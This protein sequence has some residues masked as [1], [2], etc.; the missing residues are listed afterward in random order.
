[1]KTFNIKVEGR[2]ASFLRREGAIICDN[3]DYQIKFTFDDEWIAHETKTA[4]FVWGGLYKDVEFTGDTCQ[5]PTISGA[6]Q[7]QVGVYVE[8]TELKTTTPA[9][10]PCRG[11]I[12]GQSN[13][14][15]P[16]EAKHYRDQASASADRAEEAAERSEAAAT[17]AG[18]EAARAAEAEIDKIIESSAKDMA[19]CG[20][21]TK[22]ITTDPEGNLLNKSTVLDGYLCVGGAVSV[23]SGYSLTDYIRVE[24]GAAYTFANTVANYAQIGY[25]AR[26]ISF[27]D[28]FKNYISEIN[29]GN[30][31]TRNF[32]APAGAGYVRITFKTMYRESVVLYKGTHSKY[33]G[34]SP[35]H[36]IAPQT[37]VDGGLI[38]YRSIEMDKMA[39]L[40]V[41]S[42][43]LIDTTR[44][45]GGVLNDGGH[46]TA[47]STYRTTD[48]IRVAAGVSYVVSPRWRAC[49]LYNKNKCLLSVNLTTTNNG[50][51]TPTE[52]GFVRI[53]YYS[54]QESSTQMEP[55]TAP[56]PYRA[57]REEFAQP[58][59]LNDAQ[60]QD[61]QARLGNV[62]FN[63]RLYNFGDSIGAGDGNSGTGYAEI[64]GTDNRMDFVDYAVGGATM[65]KVAGQAMS[66]IL[67]QIDNAS[68]TPPDFI[69]F[70]GG[71]NDFSQGRPLGTLTSNYEGNYDATTYIGAC[72]MAIYKFLTKYPGSAIVGV[73]VHKHGRISTT[74]TNG[75]VVTFQEMHDGFMAVCEKWCI[76]VVD[77][78][79]EGGLNTRF[80]PYCEAYTLKTSAKPNGDGT[81]PNGDGYRVFYVPKIAAKLKEIAG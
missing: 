53:S 2:V 79:T 37:Q 76:P 45:E 48:Y 39:G 27:F 19:D 9:A 49:A 18:Q 31:Q 38:K 41:S 68:P 72:E 58:Y 17:T 22:E 15:Q 25:E 62:L 40:T 5:V 81:H 24:A 78:H 32:T 21:L 55:G 75:A 36:F 66:C 63:K 42:G 20:N 44:S 11:S 23:G 54:D 71:A 57:F 28:S 50:V 73:F 35:F 7:V 6:D 74:D 77:M 3:S 34:Y 8:G 26:I 67:D 69:L 52:D 65:T 12:L 33:V 64:I 13:T 70:E 59:M 61:A 29:D 56:G 80:E 10:I 16:D 30:S 43:N 47:T 46:V 60:L 51:F 14:G 4:R 1:M